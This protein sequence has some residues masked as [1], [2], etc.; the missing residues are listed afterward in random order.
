MSYGAA[1]ANPVVD[2][3]PH[4]PAELVVD[5]NY[6]HPPGVEDDPHQA[7]KR[8][9][10]GPDIV[11]TPHNGGHWILTR[12]DDMFEVMHDTETFSSVE[13]TVPKRGAGVPPLIPNQIDPPRHGPLKSIV[14]RPLSP[15][16]V[17]PVE[18]VIRELMATRIRRLAPR[19][20]CEFVSEFT[21]VPPELFFEYAGLP[22][23][24]VPRAK[25]LMDK[26][27]A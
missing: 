19:G 6:F 25:R 24:H 2:I 23:E 15:K 10:D 3:P 11:F 22:K 8:L 12:S 21:D 5:F 16:A 17:K 14:L 20:R 1:T 13:F 26:V 27:A 9:H 7:W 4:V 18:P